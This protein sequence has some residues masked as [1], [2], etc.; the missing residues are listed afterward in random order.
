MLAAAQLRSPLRA[1][2]PP[3]R[4]SA[5][6]RRARAT[7]PPRAGGPPVID[8]DERSVSLAEGVAAWQSGVQIVDVRSAREFRAE[9]VSRA[10]NAPLYLVPSTL[11]IGAVDWAMDERRG[12]E[13]MPPYNTEFEAKLRA[14]L[15]D[16]ARAQSKPALLVCSNGQRSREACRLLAEEGY[17]ELRWVHGGMAAW[18]DAYTPRGLPRKRVV[19]G[20]FRDTGALMCVSFAA[21]RCVATPR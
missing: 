7:P 8:P 15:G 12:R 1:A 16:D 19:Q 4:L 2:A 20:V 3:A 17:T 13:K 9:A 5:P 14:A 11:P 6:R 21:A 10:K 18:L